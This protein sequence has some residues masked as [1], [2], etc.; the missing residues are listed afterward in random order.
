MNTHTRSMRSDELET[1]R[2]L[3]IWSCSSLAFTPH[4]VLP[5]L[6]ECQFKTSVALVV[7]QQ[8]LI[9]FPKLYVHSIPSW[10]SSCLLWNLSLPFS[11]RMS[12]TFLYLSHYHLVF[13]SRTEVR[14]TYWI[15]LSTNRSRIYFLKILLEA[16]VY[17]NAF[18]SAQ[19]R[20]YKVQSEHCPS[21]ALHTAWVQRSTFKRDPPAWHGS[22]FRVI[23]SKIKWFC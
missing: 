8:V 17:I 18:S 14:F 9:R 10:L 5:I 3:E 7:L 12:E 4:T 21:L 23:L 19:H 13:N 15:P 6:N 1:F 2:Q 11:T 22:W 20:D 16:C